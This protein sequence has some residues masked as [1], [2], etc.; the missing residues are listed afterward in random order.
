M[1]FWQKIK[2]SIY[3]PATENLVQ[4]IEDKKVIIGGTFDLLH[5]G[6]KVLL[7][8]AFEL[9]KVKIGLTSDEMAES[10]KARKVES[11][12]SRKIE[13][14]S[15]IQKETK[16]DAVIFELNDKFGPT[17]DE[18]FDYIVT[19]PETYKT[20]LEINNERRKLGK[21][22]IEIIRIDYVLAEDGK[23][24]SSTRIFQ[25]EIDKEGKSVKY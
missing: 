2:N 7:K 4:K 6:H 13:L 19:S 15:F 10:Y 14:E 8:R 22:S 12:L 21:K 1:N 16:N 18:D 25:G 17:L 24:I 5:K 11:F 9:G 3:G 20:A 23:P